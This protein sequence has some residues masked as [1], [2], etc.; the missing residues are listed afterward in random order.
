[1]PLLAQQLVIELD[2]FERGWWVL[3]KQRGM[4]MSPKDKAYL[5][6]V[7]ENNPLLNSDVVPLDDGDAYSSDYCGGST[8]LN[9]RGY[10]LRWGRVIRRVS[11]SIEFDE[12]SD[13]C[14]IATVIRT[15]DGILKISAPYQLS[16]RMRHAIIS[17]PFVE[18]STRKA[19]FLRIGRTKDSSKNWKLDAVSVV[20]G[21]TEHANVVIDEFVMRAGGGETV[22]MKS[23]DENIWAFGQDKSA[24]TTVESESD[25]DV[26]VKLQ[27]SELEPNMVVLRSGF[28]G[29]WGQRTLLPLTFENKSGNHYIHTY[30]NTVR[31]Q[32]RPGVFHAVVEAITRESLCDLDAPVSTR[33]LGVPYV[34]R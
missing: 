23:P 6:F 19:Q 25:L 11:K 18:R 13:E 5:E 15:F 17:K 10:P 8:R 14:I 7:I 27:T 29:K 12:R 9:E 16:T 2:R 32:P 20:R 22:A 24:V 4:V 33:F 26:A 31:P 3:F 30:E 1:M 21:G 34:I 28:M